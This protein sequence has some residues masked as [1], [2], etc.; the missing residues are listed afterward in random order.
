M[1]D[2]TV[3]LTV[4]LSG[5]QPN[6]VAAKQAL[7]EVPPLVSIAQRAVGDVGFA[8]AVDP[9]PGVVTFTA[10]AASLRAAI[11]TLRAKI[12][13]AADSLDQLLGKIDAGVPV[14]VRGVQ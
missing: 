6:W 4:D 10:N 14:T 2:V 7:A 12:G 3:L 9:S 8:A 1:A 5:L 13:D 11:A